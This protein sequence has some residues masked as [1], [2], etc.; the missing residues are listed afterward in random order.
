M[1]NVQLPLFHI[2]ANIVLYV[3]K[4]MSLLKTV[5]N[6]PLASVGLQL[7]TLQVFI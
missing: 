5:E 1:Q 3:V 7:P 6:L 4:N 2:I